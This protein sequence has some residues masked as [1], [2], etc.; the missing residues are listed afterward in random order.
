MQD[1][2]NLIWRNLLCIVRYEAKYSNLPRDLAKVLNRD[3]YK[4]SGLL[5]HLIEVILCKFGAALAP[6]RTIYHRPF[7]IRKKIHS[8][9]GHA[10]ATITPECNQNCCSISEWT[11]GC[12]HINISGYRVSPGGSGECRR[13][14]LRLTRVRLRK[15][16]QICSSS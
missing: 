8:I 16:P 5:N 7:P 4:R 6:K 11:C 2:K 10:F 12:I 15:T 1:K 14:L 13:C 9:L 3:S